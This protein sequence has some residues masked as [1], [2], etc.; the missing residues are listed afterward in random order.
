MFI[1]LQPAEPRRARSAKTKVITGR[2][3]VLTVSWADPGPL[4]GHKWDL[5]LMQNIRRGFLGN[6]SREGITKMPASAHLGG[7]MGSLAHQRC[8]H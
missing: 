3:S 7:L 1:H 6:G 2:V 8:S 5:S 4:P